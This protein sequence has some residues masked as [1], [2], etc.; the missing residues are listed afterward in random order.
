MKWD[1]A[2]GCKVTFG[3][4]NPLNRYATHVITHPPRKILLECKMDVKHKAKLSN[5]DK[6]EY[7][8]TKNEVPVMHKFRKYGCQEPPR[9]LCKLWDFT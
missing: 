2:Y 7:S 3:Q 9:K 8:C 5:C 1:I 6:C 4:N